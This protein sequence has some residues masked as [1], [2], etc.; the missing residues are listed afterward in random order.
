MVNRWP[1]LHFRTLDVDVMDETETWL[2]PKEYDNELM[3]R[4]YSF[5][6]MN[7]ANWR[8]R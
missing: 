4:E 2:L 3:A 1:E 8:V 6:R 7:R 5:F